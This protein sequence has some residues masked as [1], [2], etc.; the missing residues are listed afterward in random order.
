MSSPFGSSSSTQYVINLSGNG[1]KPQAT[2]SKQLCLLLETQHPF[3]KEY[4]D[5]VNFVSRE[6]ECE[7]KSYILSLAKEQYGNLILRY[8]SEDSGITQAEHVSHLEKDF[9]TFQTI[10]KRVDNFLKGKN[11]QWISR[12]DQ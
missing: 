10:S 2:K 1:P 12:C 8:F 9:F 3:M 4:R 5:I 6:S 11:P 7:E